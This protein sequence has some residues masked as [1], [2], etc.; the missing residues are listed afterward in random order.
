MKRLRTFMIGITLVAVG[1]TSCGQNTESKDGE[2]AGEEATVAGKM[3]DGPGFRMLIPEGWE[4]NLF[5]AGG[6]LQAYTRDMKYAVRVSRSGYNMSQADIQT[7]LESIL[8]V[9][10][11][12]PIKTMEMLG[13]NFI[14]STYDANGQYQTMYL[15]LKDGQS[16]GIVLLGP[17]HQTDPTVQAVFK[18]VELK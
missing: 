11:G 13:L 8:K 5:E 15:A 14:Y 12:T 4:H 6:S 17:E 9:H 1:F 16:I 18:S 3:M 10:K 2:T 7:N